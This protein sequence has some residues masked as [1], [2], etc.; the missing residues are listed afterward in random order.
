MR[1]L[2]ISLML[3]PAA[4]LAEAVRLDA[5]APGSVTEPVLKKIGAID[6][7]QNLAVEGSKDEWPLHGLYWSVPDFKMV[8]ETSDSV[9]ICYWTDEDFSRSKA[10]REESRRYASSIVF[11]TEKKT[12]TVKKKSWWKFWR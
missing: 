9:S 12:F 11:D 4:A 6:I 8:F 5:G 7:T 3:L 10:H 2:I 1:A